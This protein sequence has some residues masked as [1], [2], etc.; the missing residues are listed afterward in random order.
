MIVVSDT[1]AIT[2]L[3]QIGEL[4]FLKDVFGQIII[5]AAV[6]AELAEVSG[7]WEAI[8]ALNFVD[9]QSPTDTAFLAVLKNTLD[10]GEAEAIA[11]SRE[12]YADFLIIDEWRGRRVAKQN[13]IQIIGLIGILLT[14]KRKG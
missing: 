9:I 7:Q 10:D 6:E 5:P 4:E 2:N 12:L 1:T 3:F 14:A 8:N 11:L 13:G